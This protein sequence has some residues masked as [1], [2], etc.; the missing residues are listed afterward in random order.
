MFCVVETSQFY[1]LTKKFRIFVLVVQS[2]GNCKILFNI[3]QTKDYD[4]WK[5]IITTEK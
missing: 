5:I 4:Y 1:Q 3:S 2:R